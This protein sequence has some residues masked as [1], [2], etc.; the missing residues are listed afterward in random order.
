M[1]QLVAQIQAACDNI[2][3]RACFEQKSASDRSVTADMTQLMTNM[4]QEVVGEV[5]APACSAQSA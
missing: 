2:T 3:R 4:I 1:S 5:R